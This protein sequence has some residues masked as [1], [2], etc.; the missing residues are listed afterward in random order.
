VECKQS[1]QRIL[2]TK[3][4]K[5]KKKKKQKRNWSGCLILMRKGDKI[6]EKWK[7]TKFTAVEIHVDW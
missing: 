2:K 4:N 6:E 7:K 1:D 5:K 3:K